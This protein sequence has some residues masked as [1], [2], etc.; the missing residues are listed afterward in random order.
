[1]K[2]RVTEY[3]KNRE[4]LTKLTF[5]ASLY[6]LLIVLF[7]KSFSLGLTSD[8]YTFY[9]ISQAHNIKEFLYFFY[10]I[11]PY[12]FRPLPTEVFYYFLHLTR[13]NFF[14][15][16]VV[17]FLT[18]FVGLYFL[19][20]VLFKITKNKAFS[21]LTTF[22][23]AISFIHVF[24]LYMFNTFQEICL[25]TF[26]SIS[27]Y[28]YLSKKTLISLLF[29]ILALLSKETAALFPL[30]LIIYAS[31]EKRRINLEIKNL[32]PFGLLSL[33]AIFFYKTGVS[34]VEQI[35]IY[36]IHLSPSLIFNNFAWYSLWS[37][38]F[39]NFLP[40]YMKSVFLKPLPEFWNVLNL[41][42]IKIYFYTLVF[43]LFLFAATAVSY[44]LNNKK[45]TK[46]VAVFIACGFLFGFFIF[47]TLPIIHRWM[48][49]LTIP[50]IFVIFAQ[51]YVITAAYSSKNTLLRGAAVLLVLIYIY[52]NFMGIGIHESS[53]LFIRENNIFLKS[54]EVYKKDYDQIVNSGVLFFADSDFDH[55]NGSKLL[56][57]H[58]H[59]QDFLNYFFP[60]K[61]IR[62]MYAYKTTKIPQQTFV[63]ES[64]DLIPY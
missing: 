44:A 16:H 57:D 42:A 50:L 29:F 64:K 31:Y 58:Y 62:A 54:K 36:K 28:F 48:V 25:F 17:V 37:L 5:F 23:Y 2:R 20:G 35:E 12:F 24:Q 52:F 56:D 6:I 53:G 3:F 49:R 59:N 40:N 45:I 4:K 38:G 19:F 63:I 46:M 11:K 26:L 39:P 18:Y 7:N 61:K 27:S 10:P 9:K 14:I 21:Y 41:D 33:I 32:I 22:M 55:E 30:M 13:G 43:Y 8:D 60:G 15:G 51:A 34:G 1:M 47:P